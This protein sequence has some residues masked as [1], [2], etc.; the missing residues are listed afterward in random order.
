M[1]AGSLLQVLVAPPL[2]FGWWGIPA[3]GIEGAAWSFVIARTVS[4]SMTL[5]WFVARERMLS[6]RLDGLVNSAREIL[7][8]GVP[9]SATN[10]IQPLSAAITTRILADLGTSVVAGFGVASRI[11]AVVTMVVIGISAS[12]A[13]LVGQNWGARRYD[14]VREAL[15]LGYRY[16]LIW[17]AIA[18]AVMWTGGAYFAS[19]ITTDPAVAAVATLYLHIVPFSIGFFGMLNVANASFNALSKPLPPLVL[20]LSRLV[21]VYVPLALIAVELFGAPGVFAATALVNVLFGLVARGWNRRLIDRL[22]HV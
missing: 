3:L 22:V 18:A 17:G 1:T 9:A 2:I 14:R 4:L 20:S 11:D 12:S 16:C 5:W 10:L 6:F 21:L 13:P 8:V 7:H 19:L 15:R